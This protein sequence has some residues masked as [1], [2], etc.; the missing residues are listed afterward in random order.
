MNIMRK[1]YLLNSVAHFDKP[2]EGNAAVDEAA[3]RKAH[4]EAERAKVQVTSVKIEDVKDDVEEKDDEQKD[5]NSEEEKETEED[6]EKIEDQEEDKEEKKSKIEKQYERTSKKLAKETQARKAA[7]K[8]IA[9]LEARLAANPDKVLTEEDVETLSEKKANEKQLLREFNQ[10]SDRLADDAQKHLKLKDKEFN[11]LVTEALEE[12][13]IK[14]VPGEIVGALGDIDNGGAILAHMLKNLD[15]MEEF[16][17][18]KGRPVKLGLELAKLSVKLSTPIKKKISQVPDAVEPLGGKA[19][20]SD[21]LS[22]LSNKKNKTPEE[23]AE[24]VQA[25]NADILQKRANGRPN[26]R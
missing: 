5:E 17:Q 9:D 14:G 4:I 10:T 13:D 24:W 21:R 15:V 6:A 2:D 8:K 18:L 20:T 3:A 22:F 26:L 25:R 16:L 1:S 11:S 23:M 7:D 12:L 19:A